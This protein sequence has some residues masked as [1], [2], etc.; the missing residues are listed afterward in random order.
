MC[1]CVQTKGFVELVDV[2]AIECYVSFNV[3]DLTACTCV[4]VSRLYRICF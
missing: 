1:V 2:L 3:R 4:C